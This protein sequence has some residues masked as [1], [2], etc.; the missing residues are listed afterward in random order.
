MAFYLLENNKGN[1][2]PS[3]PTPQLLSQA[4][5]SPVCQVCTHQEGDIS[6]KQH[7][8]L[9]F[10]QTFLITTNWTLIEEEEGSKFVV[11]TEL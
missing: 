6:G 10:P 2:L 4:E 1:G 11:P 7:Y 9:G 8:I 3:P 5:D